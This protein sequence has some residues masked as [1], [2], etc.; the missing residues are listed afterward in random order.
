MHFMF[1]FQS[2]RI[3]AAITPELL[4]RVLNKS[5]SLL[6]IRRD[7]LFSTLHRHYF[8]S[9]FSSYHDPRADIA[10][11]ACGNSNF[12]GSGRETPVWGLSL[13]RMTACS[14]LSKLVLFPRR[15]ADRSASITERGSGPR[16]VTRDMR[17][18]PAIELS[19]W[20][21]V[22]RS[23]P[24]RLISTQKPNRDIFC[25]FAVTAGIRK[26]HS[27][28]TMRVPP[29]HQSWHVSSRKRDTPNE[30]DRSESVSYGWRSL[31]DATRSVSK[32]NILPTC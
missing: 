8:F 16:K 15:L 2:P 7:V 4:M 19:T 29:L 26:A 5:S 10:D 21:D 12:I 13:A 3:N 22:G 24:R 9:D 30:R 32:S 1:F 6:Y 27:F 14:E 17:S 31:S 23:L 11:A 18:I 25:I 20:I 28:E